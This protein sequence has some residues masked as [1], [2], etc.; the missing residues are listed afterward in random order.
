MA[1]AAIHAISRR[2]RCA[3]AAGVCCFGADATAIAVSAA[4]AAIVVFIRVA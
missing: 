2:L 4:I 3:K 1:I